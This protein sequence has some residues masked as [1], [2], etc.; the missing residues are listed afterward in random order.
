MAMHSKYILREIDL[1]L[2]LLN[3]FWRIYSIPKESKY[4]S[5][6]LSVNKKTQCWMIWFIQLIQYFSVFHCWYYSVKI[7]EFKEK[8][9]IV[10]CCFSAIKNVFEPSSSS[11]FPVKLICWRIFMFF[12]QVNANKFIIILMIGIIQHN[13]SVV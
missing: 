12:C 5:V 13:F 6:F 4:T 8:F 9:R 2:I 11:S 1:F 3:T 7:N 10:F